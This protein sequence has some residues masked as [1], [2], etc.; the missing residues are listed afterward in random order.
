[1]LNRKE[2]KDD[3][4]YYRSQ[5][6]VRFLRTASNKAETRSD[7]TLSR[8]EPFSGGDCRGIW[9]FRAAV[10][11]SLKSAEKSLKEYEEKL[12]LV[13][14][15]MQ[16]NE[17]IAKIDSML[18]ELARKYNGNQELVDGLEEIKS[19]INGLERL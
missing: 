10:H 18:L 4:Q 19:V 16:S 6:F 15:L 3:G 7:G 14:K 12:G 1:M 5:S 8:G 17:A 2:K 13:S 9:N 11:D